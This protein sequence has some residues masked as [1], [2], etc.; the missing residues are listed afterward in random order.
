MRESVGFYITVSNVEWCESEVGQGHFS[1]VS[2]AVEFALRDMLL[3]MLGGYRPAMQ[4]RGAKIRK[5]VRVDVWVM[6]SLLDTGMFDKSEA[7]DY[8]LW[9]LRERCGDKIEEE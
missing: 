8:A 6:E 2:D 9:H 5:N 1:T 7:A 3:D 4:R